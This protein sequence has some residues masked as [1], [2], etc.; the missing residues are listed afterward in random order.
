MQ[1]ELF[2]ALSIYLIR[3]GYNTTKRQFFVEGYSVFSSKMSFIT[4]FGYYLK[5]EKNLKNCGNKPFIMLL[6]SS[7]HI[8][9][10][11]IIETK[12]WNGFFDIISLFILFTRLL[13]SF[14][15]YGPPIPCNAHNVSCG[16]LYPD[17]SWYCWISP[18]HL[19]LLPEL[20]CQAVP[21]MA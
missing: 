9:P 6:N 13:Y 21:Y 7:S 2:F 18:P 8:V 17:V 19:I 15:W 12:S 1:A 4:F 11:L 3:T 5:T 14:W 20:P 16:I 10:P